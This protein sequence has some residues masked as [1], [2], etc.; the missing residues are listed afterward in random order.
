L[1]SAADDATA[2]FTDDLH[3]LDSTTPAERIYGLFQ[4]VSKLEDAVRTHRALLEA[5]EQLLYVDIIAQLG[6]VY[7][8]L[9]RQRAEQRFT[10]TPWVRILHP[11]AEFANF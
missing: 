1:Q 10:L 11:A 4:K 5:E 6:H 7:R 3:D 2:S 9:Q 8:K